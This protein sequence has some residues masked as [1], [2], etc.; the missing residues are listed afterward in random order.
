LRNSKKG[1]Q[2]DE[3]KYRAHPTHHFSLAVDISNSLSNRNIILL[4]SLVY[5]LATDVKNKLPNR[6]KGL[7]S[8][9]F[10]S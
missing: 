5:F 9:I 7:L 3:H 2:K 1:S 6:N 8:L 4:H 10:F